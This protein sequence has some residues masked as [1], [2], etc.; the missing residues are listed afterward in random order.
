M[1]ITTA[2]MFKLVFQM[3]IT[4]MQHII[5]IHARS[6]TP[7][8]VVLPLYTYIRISNEAVDLLDRIR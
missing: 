8:E 1:E 5:A 4:I 6:G 2:A 7:T 3:L